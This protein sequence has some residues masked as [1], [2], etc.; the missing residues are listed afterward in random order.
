MGVILF[1]KGRN[2]LEMRYS[3]DE[4]R[5]KAFHPAAD[6]EELK[7]YL[8]AFKEVCCGSAASSPISKLDAASRFRWLTAARST[9]VQTSKV[10]PGLCADPGETLDRL[11]AQLVEG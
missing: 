9:I 11:Q 1:C 6:L 3:V 10:H 5:V 8:A 7:N 4:A 2:F